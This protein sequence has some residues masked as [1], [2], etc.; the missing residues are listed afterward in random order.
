M[1]MNTI[2]AASYN[3]RNEL[4]RGQIGWTHRET[5][6]QVL[7]LGCRRCRKLRYLNQIRIVCVNYFQCPYTDY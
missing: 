3:F 4:I 1:K 5:D 7:F 6:G 2:R